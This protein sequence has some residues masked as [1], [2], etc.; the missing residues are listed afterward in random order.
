M[1]TLPEPSQNFIN[2]LASFWNVFFKDTAEMRAFFDGVQLNAGQL[3]LELLETVLGTSLRHAPVF[4]KRYFHQF[5]IG[6]DALFFREGASPEFDTYRFTPSDVVL[7]DVPTLMNRVVLPTAVLEAKRDFEVN[8]NAIAFFENVFNTDGNNTTI[9]LFPV[10]TVV[11][12]F[13][14]QYQ[15]VARRSWVP[16]DVRVGDYVRFRIRGGGSP[17]KIRI[18]GVRNDTLLL[19]ETRPEF[20]TALSRRS[21]E[22]SV[23]RVPFD[24][25]KS[26]IVVP[27]HPATVVRLSANATD[28]AIVPAS[29]TI[30]FSAEPFYKGFWTP[31]TNYAVGDVV[32]DPFNIPVRATVAHT[33]GAVYSAAPW[34]SLANKYFYVQDPEDHHNDGLFNVL[35]VG[36]SSLTLNRAANF[37]TTP[38]MRAVVYVVGYASGLIGA[39]QPVINLVHTFLEVGTVHITARRKQDVYVY[40]S[41]T[42][43]FDLHAVN[44]AV[45]EGVDYLV[46][47]VSGTLTILT[48]WD[49][50]FPALISYTWN[51]E[52]TTRTYTPPANW[53]SANP[54]IIGDAVIFNSVVYVCV[55][56][57]SDVSFTLSKWVQ[58]SGPFFFDKT[59]SVRQLAFWGTDALVDLETLYKNF[60][61]LLAFKH[62]S[63]EQYRAFLRGVAQLFV[64][65]PTLERFESALNVMSNLPVVRDD[66]EILRDYS[67]GIFS[68]GSDGQLIDS[69]EGRDGILTNAT[70]QFTAPSATFFPTDVGAVLR[71]RLSAS[72][73]AN[74]IVT[75][76]VS[77]TTVTVSPTPPDSSGLTWNFTHV[78]LTRRFRTSSFVFTE[79]DQDAQILI[80]GASNAR[81]NGVFRILSVENA[82]T[83]ILETA[84]GFIDEVGLNWKL[85]REKVQ[86]VTT[87]R[88]TYEIPLA[89]PVRSDILLPASLNALTF[90]A[91][92]TLT[93]AFAVTDYI[94]D[95]TWWHNISIPEEL[96]KLTVESAARR[97]VSPELIEHRVTPL[98]QALVGDFG[99]AVGVD[100]EGHS[101]IS[102]S[103]TATWYGGD[104]IVL[105]FAPNVPVG[106]PRDVGRYVT[107]TGP[108]VSAQFEIYSVDTSGTVLRLRGF[109][110]R[111]MALAIP[112]VV[113]NAVLSPLLYRRTVGFV[114]MDRFLKYHALRV[115][116]DP[117][118]PIPD[119]FL[120][121][122]TQLLREAKPAFTHVY[123][124]SPLDFFERIIVDDSNMSVGI[125]FPADEPFLIADNNAY[126]GPPG[127][128]K[129]N[130]AFQFYTG[131][132]VIP[133]APG[134]Y[135]LTPVVPPAGAPPR[136]VRFHAVKGW[137]DL[138]VLVGGKR[139]TEGIHYTLDR[140]NGTVTV[141]T[142]GLPGATTFNYV[143]VILRTRFTGDPLDPGETPICVGGHDPSTW[144][145]AT[146]TVTS[147]G[148]IDRAVQLTIGP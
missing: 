81:N 51:K 9:P 12:S 57:N 85:S 93:D 112:P 17:Y 111:E 69:D 124:E 110:P 46:D 64:I 43:I 108:D 6:E 121:E 35:S 68:S 67:N 105:S 117:S 4:S 97:R 29:T 50:L 26:G 104:S 2:A 55:T 139:L 87:S 14:A 146:Q 84:F 53:V 142:P 54:Y 76:V 59:H 1:P 99:L 16:D 36:V 101:G 10:R 32:T 109:P 118:T 138:S 95:P 73:Y 102:R 21:F 123:F 7:Q 135:A 22:V 42:G 132:Q 72:S 126:V 125:E 33:S 106:N 62:P 28:V 34:D 71:I 113:F 3:Y 141:L 136:V 143:V 18:L 129:A 140:L 20:T 49:P 63:S 100:D 91:F 107:L 96:L 116:V 122:A 130:D 103:G 47:Y 145:A 128:L 25:E 92:E 11:K 86:K 144:W 15:D 82:S 89:V 13:V 70:S 60:G 74:Y 77:G 120:G 19:E 45:E 98:D 119:E 39:P 41:E 137:F 52:I 38:S 83:V 75:A 80:S 30:D 58:F 8:A 94:Q 23:L 115:N 44:Q 66:G 24:A 90:Q 134:T 147:A 40:N 78:A 65:G 56:A 114:M 48:G 31:F 61:Y 88:A 37:S 5:T 127:L 131:A 79:A 148:L 133:A 27:E